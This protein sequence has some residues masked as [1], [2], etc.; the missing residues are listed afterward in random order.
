MYYYFILRNYFVVQEEDT[1]S[2]WQ[3]D[4]GEVCPAEDVSTK[5]SEAGNTT[6]NINMTE[7]DKVITEALTNNASNNVLHKTLSL[8]NL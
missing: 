5:T 8:S 3:F 4:D 1:L 6:T 7:Q 2:P